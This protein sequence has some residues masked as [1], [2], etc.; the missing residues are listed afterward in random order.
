MP[1]F[2][3]SEIQACSMA[4]VNPMTTRSHVKWKSFESAGTHV[5]RR[6]QLVCKEVF[7]P[8][9]SFTRGKSESP[10]IVGPI[11]LRNV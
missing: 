1:R 4:V 2:P 10:H 11:A 5:S 7:P 8:R 9:N 6:I 3:E